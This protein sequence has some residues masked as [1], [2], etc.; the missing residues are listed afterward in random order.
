M[1]ILKEPLLHFLAI[2][3]A[4]FVLYAWLNPGDTGSGQR[5][6]VDEGR[7]QSLAASFERTWNRAPSSDELA[8]LIEEFALEEIYYRQALEMGLDE[9]DTVIRRRLRQK[10]EFLATSMAT[11]AQP[12][13]SDLQDFLNQYQEQYRRPDRYS[14]EQVYINP[15]RNGAN[16]ERR[17]AE[18]E[19][20]LEKGVDVQGD[21]TLIARTF[22]DTSS[23][24]L[25]NVLGRGFAQQLD[26]LPLEEWSTPLRS[27]LGFHFVKVHARETGE[28]P[29]L[30]DIRAAVLRDW[31]Y[32]REREAQREIERE[33]LAK[34]EIVVHLP[35]E[36]GAP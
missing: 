15:E 25:D 33:L 24:Q 1:K 29:A 12:E 8:R 5:I 11:V 7:V 17:L 13:D 31:T 9:N 27:G 10:L 23:Y 19:S 32:E 6:V 34:Y 21:E 36:A 30:D 20:A 28:V 35:R 16:L 18:V 22:D 14:F 2:G 26:D 4:F 3:A